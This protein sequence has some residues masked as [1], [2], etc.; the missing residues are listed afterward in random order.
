M[1][2]NLEE[3]FREA[4]YGIYTKAMSEGNYNAW[5]F[6]QM[7]FDMGGVKTAK[8]LINSN[9]IHYGL[10]KLKERG[11]LDLTVEAEIWGNAKWHPLFTD[12]ELK[13]VEQ[14]LRELGYFD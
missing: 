1:S 14:R 11:R 8:R 13:K 5:V 2:E 4:M 9:K 3:A 12:S 6:R 10:R 7:L